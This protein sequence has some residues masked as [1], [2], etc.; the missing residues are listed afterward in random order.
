MV[1]VDA[2][3]NYLVFMPCVAAPVSIMGSFLILL[4]IYRSSQ[5]GTKMTTYHRL[6]MGISIFDIIF[7][8]GFAL[9]PLPMPHELGFPGAHG[10]I[11]TCSFQ[12]FLLQVGMASLSYSTM[13][14]I[15]Y[16]LMVCFNLTESTITKRAEPL[17]HAIP[18]FFHVGTGIAGFPCAS[19]Q[20][21][22]R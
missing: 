13:L 19:V 10:N 17:F 20:S 5:A 18:I 1:N 6:S 12:A 14:M 4:T 2:R 16:V 9:G 7:S 11:A 21:T 22:R 8:I 3:I 15:Y